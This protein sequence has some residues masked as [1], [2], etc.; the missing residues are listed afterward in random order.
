MLMKEI[1]DDLNGQACCTHEYSWRLTNIFK[2]II[3]KI[4]AGFLKID[5]DKIDIKFIREDKWIK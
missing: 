1:K 5:L 3:I 4:S 2:G